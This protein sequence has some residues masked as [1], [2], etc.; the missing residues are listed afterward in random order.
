[1]GNINNHTNSLLLRVRSNRVV[2]FVADP[3]ARRILARIKCGKLFRSCIQSTIQQFSLPSGGG[4]KRPLVRGDI[5]APFSGTST[6]VFQPFLANKCPG[7]PN[8][9]QKND[10]E[11]PA[12]R[13]KGLRWNPFQTDR[14]YHPFLSTLL[15]QQ[16]PWFSTNYWKIDF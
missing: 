5:P 16:V 3:S 11:I 9:L 15:G 6:P 4:H 10:F 12:R 8:Q 1:M 7:F 2:I 14:V 13:G